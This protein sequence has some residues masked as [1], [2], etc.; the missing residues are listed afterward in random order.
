MLLP[1]AFAA[2]MVAIIF[3]T[4]MTAVALAA[5]IPLMI[6]VDGATRT[7]PAS[8]EVLATIVIRSRP[9]RS[10]IRGSRP[11]AVVPGPASAHWIPVA[12]DPLVIG[13]GLRWDPIHSRRRRG[14]A[15][16]DTETHLSVGDGGW[17]AQESRDGDCL[18]QF[19]HAFQAVQMGR[20]NRGSS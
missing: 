8:F 16:A 15:D 12:F 11:V 10:L 20:Q 17:R 3:P 1:L 18:Q 4:F 6:V 2:A 9:V 19:S 5:S 13:T 7:F 14:L